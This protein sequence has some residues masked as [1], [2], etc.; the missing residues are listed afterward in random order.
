MSLHKRT[1]VAGH[2]DMN[3]ERPGNEVGTGTKEG[4]CVPSLDNKFQYCFFFFFWQMQLYKI[5]FKELALSKI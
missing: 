5:L 2:L 3:W 1:T 4:H